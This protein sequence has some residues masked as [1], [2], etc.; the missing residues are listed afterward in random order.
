MLAYGKIPSPFEWPITLAVENIVVNVFIWEYFRN[1]LVIFDTVIM[2]Y[3]VDKHRQ[4]QCEVCPPARYSSNRQIDHLM[5]WNQRHPWRPATSELQ[6]LCWPF[7][8]W[9]SI[10][11]QDFILQHFTHKQ[12]TLVFCGALIL[13]YSNQTSPFVSKHNRSLIWNA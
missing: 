11:R 2:I 3:S 13:R 10:L 12:S 1:L 7:R 9:C 8:T 5:V 6:V 4:A